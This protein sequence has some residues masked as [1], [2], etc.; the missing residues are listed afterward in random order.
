MLLDFVIETS[1]PFRGFW[2]TWI[3]C[4]WYV[5]ARLGNMLL[6]FALLLP[7]GPFANHVVGLCV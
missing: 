2:D 1:W 6:D 5:T 7:Y 3:L 4:Y